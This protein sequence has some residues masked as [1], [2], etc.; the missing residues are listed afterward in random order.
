MVRWYYMSESTWITGVFILSYR[1]SCISC[2]VW[3]RMHTRARA[4]IPAYLSHECS[5]RVALFFEP[6]LILLF[7]GG[8]VVNDKIWPNFLSD[9]GTNVVL[10][11]SQNTKMTY[12]FRMQPGSHASTS[13]RPPLSRLAFMRPFKHRDYKFLSSFGVKVNLG[14]PYCKNSQRYEVISAVEICCISLPTSGISLDPLPR[15]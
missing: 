1:T 15:F 14:Q 8:E 6:I 9:H 7:R 13:S 12:L 4:K 11:H 5:L 10:V 2:A 3:S